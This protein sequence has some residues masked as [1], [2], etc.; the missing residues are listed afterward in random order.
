MWEGLEFLSLEYKGLPMLLMEYWIYDIFFWKK[1]MI[2]KKMKVTV[3]MQ[4]SMLKRILKFQFS[5][6]LSCSHVLD[7]S[8]LDAINSYGM[9]NE[10]C[11]FCETNHICLDCQRFN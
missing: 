4:M 6:S 11:G 1:K 2:L 9:V 10:N 8:D 3:Q 5:P 7:S